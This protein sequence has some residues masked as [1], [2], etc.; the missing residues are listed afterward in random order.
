MRAVKLKAEV[1]RDRTLHLELPAEVTEGP[2][3]VI[4]LLDDSSE[5]A[6]QQPESGTLAEFLADS[7]PD[8][9]FL[10]SKEQIDSQVA[11]ER[12]S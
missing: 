3:E 7:R 11:T 10:R 2:A 1:T 6:S 9:R 5:M 4:I 12:D 8:P